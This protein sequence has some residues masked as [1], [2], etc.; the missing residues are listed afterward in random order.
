MPD[1]IVGVDVVPLLCRVRM[2]GNGSGDVDV[3]SDCVSIQSW[4]WGGMDVGIR[5]YREAEWLP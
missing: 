2:C 3:V 1:S 5:R 4:G